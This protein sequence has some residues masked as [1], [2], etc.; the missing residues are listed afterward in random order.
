MARLLLSAV[1]ITRAPAMT[2]DNY[3][4]SLLATHAVD[5]TAKSPALKAANMVLPHVY[6]WGGAN[7]VGDVKASGSFAKGTAVHGGCDI[8]LFISLS[9]TVGTALGDIYFGLLH[10]ISR[11]GFVARQQNVSI[12]VTVD[13]FHVDLVPARRLS[14]YGG[15]HS[16]YRSRVPT[17]T[18]T[19]IDV[20]IREVHGS[21]R[22]D[23]IR[24]LKL[25][26]LRHGI[27]FPS[28]YLELAVLRALY[29]ARRGD[30][31][32]NVFKVLDFLATD[33]VTATFQD[34]A[35]TANRISDDL[36]AREKVAV[37][38]AAAAAVAATTWERVVW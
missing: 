8:D 32:N 31:A 4:L 28:F 9:S 38:R 10:H 37:A 13:G 26:K 6:A 12:G 20:H 15:D 17:W 19:N 27:R 5:L 35:N 30:L 22:Q 1:G 7:I 3:L 25:W 2:A 29:G 24:I 36:D 11:S 21:G 16:L 33:F 23:E 14:Q 34:P 18:K